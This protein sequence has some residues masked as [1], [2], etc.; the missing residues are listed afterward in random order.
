MRMPRLQPLK[1]ILVGGAVWAGSAAAA[2]QGETS[3]SVPPSLMSAAE[4]M[5]RIVRSMPGVTGGEI[6]AAP[7]QSGAY[8]VLAYA[9]ADA[10]GR[11]RF[12]EIS[13]FEI[14]GISDAP[15][16]FDQA[17]V[18]NDPVAERLLPVWKGQCRAGPGYITSV[19]R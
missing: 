19:P 3:P 13:L 4:C 9:F 7:T 11:R 15:Y 18:Q 5:A 14:T 2:P 8:P 6:T 12:T 1:W 10:S 16:V 17:D